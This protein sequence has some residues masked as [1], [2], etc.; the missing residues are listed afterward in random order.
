MKQ[1]EASG[2]PRAKTVCVRVFESPHRVQPAISRASCG[3]RTARSV[4]VGVAVAAEGGFAVA[5]GV[6]DAV[7]L[8][9]G[10]G[11]GDG[12]G[13]GEGVGRGVALGAGLAVAARAPDARGVRG[14]PVAPDACCCSR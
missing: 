2:L 13:P 12:V 8:G 11:T 5:R 6:G 1:I 3:R 14:I 7:G 10:L 9:A 4:A